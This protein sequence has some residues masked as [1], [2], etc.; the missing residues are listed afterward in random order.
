MDSKRFH[1]FIIQPRFHRV[2]ALSCIATQPCGQFAQPLADV[3]VL[4]RRIAPPLKLL[5]LLLLPD[6]VSLTCS[7]RATRRHLCFARSVHLSHGRQKILLDRKPAGRMSDAANHV[8]RVT[9]QRRCDCRDVGLR[10]V[11]ITLAI[12]A[13]E[14]ARSFRRVLGYP[15][16]VR[17]RKTGFCQGDGQ[18]L[19]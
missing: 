2:S 15:R 6:H 5:A 8:L 7:C 10:I 12:T 1:L 9:R 18:R 14:K 13:E 17:R 3:G 11:C 19:E 4:L 16:L